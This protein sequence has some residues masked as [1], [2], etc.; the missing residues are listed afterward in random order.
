M[1]EQQPT[2]FSPP[3]PLVLLPGLDGTG[4]LFKW[5]LDALP[6]EFKPI[7]VPLPREVDDYA[8]LEARV[9]RFIPRDQPFAILGESFSGP[10]ALRL[11][12]R[13]YENL[14]GVILIASFITQ[15]VGWVPGFA[16]YMLHPLIFHLPIPIP[17]LRWLLLDRNPPAA[18]MNGTLESLRS[19]DPAILAG[20]TKAALTVDVTEAFV[21]CPAPI[22]YLGGTQD[23]LISSQTAKRMKA[24][25]PDIEC[26]MVDAPHFLLQR[27]PAS[28]AGAIAE[29]LRRHNPLK[30]ASFE[31]D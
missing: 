29:F 11:A 7:I 4:Q 27:A 19:V 8:A 14:V 12:A 13:G 28:A 5:F 6:S 9:A 3:L 31:L 10:L 15:P 24:L 25:R 26:I 23:R 20:R 1:V 18:L 2:Q 22:L 30:P 17:L 21:A 16:R